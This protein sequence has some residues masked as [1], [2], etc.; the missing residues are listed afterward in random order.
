MTAMNLHGSTLKELSHWLAEKGEKP[1]RAAQIFDW[2][3]KKG[4]TS[5]ESMTDLPASLRAE[6]PEHLSLSTITLL[7]VQNS[8]VI[9]YQ[10]QL[11]DGPKF[12]TSLYKDKEKVTLTLASQA[13]RNLTAGEIIEQFYQ[14][15]ARGENIT[16]IAFKE[17]GEPLE[18]L[19]EVLKAIRL[20]CDKQRFAFPVTRIALH[21]VGIPEGIVRL[22]NEAPAVKLVLSLHA[23][24][25][26]IREK[27]FP[28]AR[29]FPLNKIFKELIDYTAKVERR[30]NFEYMLIPGVND[31]KEHAEELVALLKSQ[32]STLKLIPFH[33]LPGLP[34]KKP[35]KDVIER[36]K[37]ITST[38]SQG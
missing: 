13:R 27:I 3:Y 5:W 2:I 33:P 32:S 6:L 9:K 8:H 15:K 17:G 28:Q 26:A 25:Q 4:A 19:T 20:L 1:F 30:V 18:N 35:H 16:H 34:N 24:S 38:L 21:T 23:P 36:F 22:G 37:K 10:W 31:R 11:S 12:V 7:A 14:I 29:K